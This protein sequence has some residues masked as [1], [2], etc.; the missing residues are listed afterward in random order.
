VIDQ[1]QRLVMNFIGDKMEYTRIMQYNGCCYQC[2]RLAG[3]D[4]SKLKE[5][6]LCEFHSWE[7][8][9]IKQKEKDDLVNKLQDKIKMIEDCYKIKT[10]SYSDIGRAVEKVL[11]DS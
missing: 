6:D 2:R 4:Y 7:H 10:I 5:T 3:N 9:S 11:F 1:V 8:N